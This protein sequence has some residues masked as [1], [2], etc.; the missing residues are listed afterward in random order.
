[1][2]IRVSR[3]LALIIQWH[4]YLPVCLRCFSDM[5]LRIVLFSNNLV[6]KF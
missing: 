3:I 5:A 2:F 4:A 6:L 1:M